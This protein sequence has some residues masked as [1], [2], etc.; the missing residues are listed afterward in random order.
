MVPPLPQTERGA[1]CPIATDAP[2]ERILYCNGTNVLWRSTAPLVAGGSS[3]TPEDVFCWRGHA[4]RTTCAAMGPNGQWVASGDIG[5]AIRVWGAKG[6]HVLKNEYKLWDGTVKDVSWS[7]DSTRIVAAGDG[8]EVRACAM[9]WDTG[10]KTGEVGGHSKQINSISFRSQRPFR[11]ATGGEDMLV[12]F[13]QGPP[14]KY[15]KSHTLHTN[16]VN[17]VRYSPDGAYVVSAGSDSKVCLYEGKDGEFEK[18]FA[19]PDGISGSL[20]AAAWSPDSARFVTAGGDKRIRIWDRE[21]GAQV[22]ESLVGAGALEDM[23]VG[24]TWPTASRIIS[25]CLD[26]RVLFWDV[27]ADGS[28]TLA[29]T[30]DGTQGALTCLAC[31]ASTGALL[32]AGGD[33]FVA[34]SPPGKATMKAKIGKGVQHILAH[35]A[36]F[37]GPSEAFIFSLDDCARRL[38]VESCAII[39]EPI[40]IKEF[41]V[42][43]AW[44]DVEET[45]V[46]VAGGKHNLHCLNAGGVEWTKSGALP[47]RPTALASLPSKGLVAVGLE[48]PDVTVAGVQSSEYNIQLV[49]VT[50]AG[51]A[52][53]LALGQVLEGHLKEISAM[54]FS[55]SGEHLASADAGNKILVWSLEAGAA[56]LIIS[57]WSFHTSRITSVDWLAGGKR[58]VSGAL[59]QHLYVWDID[60]PKE[61]VHVSEAHKAGVSA[62]AACGEQSFAS[63]GNDGFLRVYQLE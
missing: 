13:H 61:R 53:G 63:V 14:F 15:N 28:A 34:V 20:W 17:C 49:N 60:K 5:G 12:A 9:I 36:G 37:S 33:G 7:A 16:F 56:K 43:A 22:C 6:D 29:A 35:S 52:D 59:D 2:G 19:K 41:A 51:S 3:E 30:V 48:R 50:D 25:V 8:K 32:Q 57:D 38:S 55:P 23:Q 54:K 31:D 39:G 42:G 45:R 40:E 24:V 1:F 10:S 62:V 27:A 26:G 21:A 18:E 58:L 11:I 47:R 46:L 44:L 4:R